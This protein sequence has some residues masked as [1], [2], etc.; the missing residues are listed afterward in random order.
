MGLAAAVAIASAYYAVAI[1]LILASRLLDGLD[2]AVARATQITDFGGYLDIVGDFVFYVSVPVA[3]AVAMPANAVPAAFLVASF[4]IT[5]VSFLAYAVMAAKRGRETAAHGGKSFFYDT[6]LAEGS[7]TIAVFLAMCVWPN[8]FG[9]LAFFYT[10]LCVLTVV[11]RTL[12]ARRDFSLS[13]P[14][15]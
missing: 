13:G 2:G 8:Y 4:A 6:G 1:A 12:A 15:G 9:P 11:Q 5:G 14:P 10:A 7:E 3:F